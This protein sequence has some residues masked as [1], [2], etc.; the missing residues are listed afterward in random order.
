[1]W[2]Y[3]A[4]SHVL[5]YIIPF[6]TLL[7][8]YIVLPYQ[9]KVLEKEACAGMEVW[10]EPPLYE[11][12]GDDKRLQECVFNTLGMDPNNGPLGMALG[13]DGPGAGGTRKGEDAITQLVEQGADVHASRAMFTVATNALLR[14]AEWGGASDPHDS[15]KLGLIRLLQCREP[16]N[17]QYRELET[18][19]IDMVRKVK[20]KLEVVRRVIQAMQGTPFAQLVDMPAAER[21]QALAAMDND[22]NV[23]PESIEKSRELLDM[24]VPEPSLRGM[25]KF[26]T[27]TIRDVGDPEEKKRVGHTELLE[28]LITLGGSVNARDEKGLT[29][30]HAAAEKGREKA[31]KILLGMGAGASRGV[32]DIYGKTPLDRLEHARRAK[33]DFNSTFRITGGVNMESDTREVEAAAEFMRCRHLLTV[34]PTA[35]PISAEEGKEGKE[36]TEGKEG[37][38]GSSGTEAGTTGATGAGGAEPS[39]LLYP[40]INPECSVK[41]TSVQCT[42]YHGPESEATLVGFI[43]SKCHGVGNG[44]VMPEV[45]CSECWMDHDC[46]W[47]GGTVPTTGCERFFCEPCCPEYLYPKSMIGEYCCQACV[48]PGVVLITD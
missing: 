18:Q 44:E 11:A 19:M 27:D 25:E 26:L 36:D 24:G 29:L 13:A 38:G 37:G 17:V 12:E 21:E 20:E 9:S 2:G 15:S 28:L 45:Y 8:N 16:D 4:P 30:L 5:T 22:D 39:P 10:Y 43:C 32:R 47:C 7:S 23:T 42:V 1:M 41:I 40:C 46:S 3:H 33:L 34:S 31:I 48:P 35:V 14:C 6:D